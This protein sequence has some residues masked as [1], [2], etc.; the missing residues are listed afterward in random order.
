MC[1]LFMHVNPRSISLVSA[2]AF[3]APPLLFVQV[4]ARGVDLPRV[5]IGIHSPPLSTFRSGFAQPVE[6]RLPG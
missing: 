6:P 2:P 5:R 3:T 4:N 1:T